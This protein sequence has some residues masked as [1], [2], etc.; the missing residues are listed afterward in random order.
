MKQSARKRYQEPDI[1][2]QYIVSFRVSGEEKMMIDNLAK[3]SGK[4]ASSVL[5]TMLQRFHTLGD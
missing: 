5:R 2:N 3:E 4:S 1:Y